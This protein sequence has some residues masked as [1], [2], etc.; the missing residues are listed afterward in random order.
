MLRA[1]GPARQIAACFLLLPATVWCRLLRQEAAASK[2][3]IVIILADDLGY[4]DLSI[5]GHPT[6]M[7]PHLDRLA[8]DGMR[9]SQFYNAASLCTPSRAALLT[10]RLP[11]RLGMAGGTWYGGVLFPDSP[12]GL[13]KEDMTIGELAKKAGYATMALG[14][15]HVGHKPEQLPHSRGFDSYFGIPYSNDMGRSAWLEEA[16]FVPLPLMQNSTVIEQPANLN[17]LEDKYVQR[18]VS[19]IQEKAAQNKP[20]LLYLAWNRVHVPVFARPSVCNKSKRGLYGTAVEDMD[21][22]VGIVMNAIH[23]AGVDENTVI[24]FTSDNGPNLQ[25][26]LAGGDTGVFFE[27]KGTTWEGGFRAPAFIR[28]K[29]TVRRGAVSEALASTID[30]WPT[31][32]ELL[33]V[34]DSAVKEHEVDGRSLL[35]LL[36]EERHDQHQCIFYYKGTPSLGLPPRQNDPNPG[37]W[38][39]RCN[40]HKMHFVSNCK[41]M[42]YFGDF[43]CT[44]E[45][46]TEEHLQ[47][48]RGDVIAEATFNRCLQRHTFSACS[49]I[50]GSET[51][52]HPQPLMFNVEVDPGEKYPIDPDTNEYKKAFDTIMKAKETHESTLFNVQ[53]QMAMT[54]HTSLQPC[55]NQSNDC[56]CQPDNFAPSEGVCKPVFGK[57][58]NN[59]SIDEIRKSWVNQKFD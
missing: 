15:W 51:K 2:P 35:P 9:F 41:V 49:M 40:T 44:T 53:N 18:A 31:I 37:L 23:E 54:A 36:L 14:K 26:R 13:R 32:R 1:G 16:A 38:A 17:T 56:V 29:G 34:S 43:R 28:W 6:I 11:I 55:C 33:G 46:P 45:E 59:M 39:I 3:N 10:G 52:F 24:F 30:F 4:G 47:Q 48:L 50:L 42:Q 27:G 22:N 58:V 5:T 21:L 57:G 25:M 8:M 19:F 7:T 12:G 20:F